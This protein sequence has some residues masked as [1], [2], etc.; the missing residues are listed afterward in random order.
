VVKIL[1]LIGFIIY[2]GFAMSKTYGTPPFPIRGNVF[3][4]NAGKWKC[5]SNEFNAKD[6]ILGFALF[7]FVLFVIFAVAWEKFLGRS[8]ERLFTKFSQSNANRPGCVRFRKIFN[9]FSW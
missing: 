9:R 8:V 3:S 4:G 2:F 5:L 1:F 6:F 7:F